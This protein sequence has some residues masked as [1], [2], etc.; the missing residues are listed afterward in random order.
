ML[1]I[2]QIKSTNITLV[3]DRRSRVVVQLNGSFFL[4]GLSAQEEALFFNISTIQK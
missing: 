1:E 2:S 3:G 4:I